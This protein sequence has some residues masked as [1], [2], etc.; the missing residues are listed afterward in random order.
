MDGT[1]FALEKKGSNFA[2]RHGI[3][4][5]ATKPPKWQGCWVI[6]GSFNGTHFLGLKSVVILRNA[7]KNSALFG[8]LS[9]K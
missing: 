4:K 3:R 5:K 7:P 6:Q 8:L 9:Y 1:F 2:S